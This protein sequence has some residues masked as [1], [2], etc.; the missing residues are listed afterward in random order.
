MYSPHTLFPLDTR[1]AHTTAL[2]SLWHW[3]SRISL[4]NY[5]QLT[6]VI[7][8]IH[9]MEVPNGVSFFYCFKTGVLMCFNWNFRMCASAQSWMHPPTVQRTVR[10]RSHS[11]LLARVMCR[12]ILVGNK[13]DAQFLLWYVYLNSLRVS[14]NYVLILRRRIVWIQLLVQG[15]AEKPDDF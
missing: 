4:D 9:S 6:K 3:A 14:S 1:N 12:N 10:K 13:F 5:W 7:A 11:L 8:T 15:P 2:R